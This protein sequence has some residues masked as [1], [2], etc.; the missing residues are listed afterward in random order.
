MLVGDEV[1]RSACHPPDTCSDPSSSPLEKNGFARWMRWSRDESRK[2]VRGV[3]RSVR[4]LL[5]RS[6]SS[7]ICRPFC[8]RV[9]EI[10]AG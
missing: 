9:E 2:H 1:V 3:I 8:H 6:V 10:L 4:C 7:E 5:E